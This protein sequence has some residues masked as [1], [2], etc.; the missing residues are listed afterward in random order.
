MA[1]FRAHFGACTTL[2]V[3]ARVALTNDAQLTAQVA[4]N[5]SPEAV[6]AARGAAPRH[7]CV[8]MAWHTHEISVLWGQNSSLWGGA[9]TLALG[10]RGMRLFDVKIIVNPQGVASFFLVWF[11]LVWLLGGSFVIESSI[12]YG[13]GFRYLRVAVA[14]ETW[15]AYEDL[16]GSGFLSRRHLALSPFP[17]SRSV[18]DRQFFPYSFF[19]YFLSFS[20][21][22][23]CLI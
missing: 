15:Q 21:N 3:A 22:F 10:L 9:A 8:T 4:T 12:A 2:G 14:L 6:N 1:F 20:Y 19:V 16:W 23:V 11:G 7:V 13:I 18:F 17:F 5:G